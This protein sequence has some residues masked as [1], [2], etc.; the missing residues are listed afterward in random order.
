MI[1]FLTLA[2]EDK[3]GKILCLFEL[4]NQSEMWSYGSKQKQAQ[5]SS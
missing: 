4:K 1:S 5:R 2:A 3:I